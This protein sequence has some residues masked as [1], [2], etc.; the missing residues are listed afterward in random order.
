MQSDAF[1]AQAASALFKLRRAVSST[2]GA[3]IEKKSAEIQTT[4]QNIFK[5]SVRVKS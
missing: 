5:I 4:T 2:D 1:D 3:E